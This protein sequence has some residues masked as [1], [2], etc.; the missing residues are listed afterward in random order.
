MTVKQI[1]HL[2][3]Y[4]GYYT[5][6]VDGI[7]G[8]GTL[9]SVKA[10][11][12]DFGGLQVDGIAGNETQK[13]LKHAVAYGVDKSEESKEIPNFWVEIKNFTRNEFACPCPRCGGFPVEPE[14]SLVRLADQIRDHFD[15]PMTISSGVR[16]QAHNDELKGSVPN[17]RHVKGKAM[18]FCIRGKT[19]AQ[20]LTYVNTIPHRYAYHIDG[21]YVHVDVE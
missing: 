9:S 8:P 1:Q 20:I 4:L 6:D 17:S 21:S 3:A 16:C 19:S 14:E 18:D 2:L 7:S 10:F 11:Q 13:A 15:S 12:K 5:L